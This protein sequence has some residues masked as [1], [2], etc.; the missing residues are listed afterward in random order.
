[1][2]GPAAPQVPAQETAAAAWPAAGAW[3]RL[4]AAAANKNTLALLD[5]AVVSG[6]NFVTTIVVARWCGASELG[7]YALGFSLLV[8]WAC[9]QESLIALPYTIYRH[10]HRD[11]SQ[12]D[13]AGS[14]LAH[15]G[16]LSLLAL[17]L[18]A[19]TTALLPARASLPGLA[20][21][22][23][24][25]AAVVPFA[26]LR[27]FGRRFAFAH[28]RMGEAVVL[29]VVAAALQLAGLAALA[30]A[31]ALSA[32][33]AYLAVGAACAVTSAVWLYLSRRCFVIRRAQVLPTLRQSWTL[34][35]WLFASQV[36]LSVQS[37]FIH[38]LLAWRDGAEAT[39]VYAA[40]MTVVQFSN[41]LI[42][43]ISNALMPRAAQALVEGGAREL[44]HVVLQTTLLLS[45][46]MG[47]FCAAVLLA[48]DQILYLVYHGS[49]Y[50]D[51]SQTVFVLALAM[52]ASAVGMPASNGLAAVE[53][54]G[55]VFKVGLLALAVSLLL[56]PWLVAWY[57]VAG[58]AYGFLAGNVVGAAGRWAVL[59]LFLHDHRRQA[60][61]HDVLGRFAPAA[62]APRWAIEELSAGSQ[63]WV[64][65]ARPAAPGA[66]ELVVKLY[67]PTS[68]QHAAILREQVEAM[69]HLHARL[70]GGTSNGWRL[71]APA[72]LYVCDSPP[73]LI[74][75][76]VPGLPL[77]A[78][79]AQAPLT[80]DDLDALAEAVV[81]GMQRCWASA[82]RTH[83]DFNFD[84][85]LCDPAARSLAFVD[86]GLLEGE[87]LY[88]G[89]GRRWGP[90]ARDLARLLYETEVDVKRTFGHPRVRQRRR[91]LAEK[92]LRAFLQLHVAA[93]QQDG[94]LDEIRA[95]VRAHLDSLSTSWSPRGLWCA[96]LK[97]IARRR[98]EGILGSIQAA[99]AEGK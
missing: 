84:N 34:G 90:A 39:G 24:V 44:R 32:S 77:N 41:P 48:G 20:A 95:C 88:A 59:A 57:G 51:H 38:W 70:H 93:E 97:R 49:Q 40:C 43:G 23:G 86:A 7:I 26:L 50:Q 87:A 6:T 25:L 60:L 16:L 99:P 9:V 52:L 74:M 36:T 8:T 1:M 19:G 65:A 28:L 96:L 33:T 89:A 64:F 12:A 67:R 72:A 79:L 13:Y 68:R 55:A 11:G 4:R 47:L 69:T 94:L 83:G 61:V 10:R 42:L 17:V 18:L 82:A 15:Q 66:G 22:T 46:A 3:A 63:A 73:A 58:A 98:I 56:V 5:Q 85:I 31:E 92:I 2:S 21:V 53:R 81:G 76:R 91:R 80:G 30:A 27:E 54:P 75:T 37:Y 62:G 35:R 29:D 45:V 71:H 14:I 78:C